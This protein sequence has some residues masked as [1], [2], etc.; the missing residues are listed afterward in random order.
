MILGG[1]RR[2][3]GTSIHGTQTEKSFR[4]GLSSGNNWLRTCCPRQILGPERYIDIH[5]KDNSVLGRSVIPALNG[6]KM[7][8]LG[9]RYFCTL[10]SMN[11]SGSNSNA[12]GPQ[13]S[14]RRWSTTKAWSTGILSGR[15]QGLA[16]GSLALGQSCA[17]MLVLKKC[18]ENRMKVQGFIQSLHVLE[19]I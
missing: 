3:E 8:G 12:S 19:G 4:H 10:S 1:G 13:R 5:Q 7:N 18:S 17:L 14:F 9:R 6:R 11:L 2:N 16:E 15:Y